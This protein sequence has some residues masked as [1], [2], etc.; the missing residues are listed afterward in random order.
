[1]LRSPIA[2][3]AVFIAF[4]GC[5]KESPKPAAAGPSAK[6]PE[7]ERSMDPGDGAALIRSTREIDWMESAGVFVGI[8]SFHSDSDLDVE[9]AADDAV[10]LAY[11]L[12]TEMELLQPRNT[13]ILLAG[14]PSKESSRAK[15]E[16]LRGKAIVIE[17]ERWRLAGRYCVNGDLVSETVA[18]MARE[19]G[20]DG[21]LIV[22]F[23]THGVT[24]NGEHRLLTADASTG[25]P[26]GVALAT[27]LAAIR[28]ER[29]ERLLLLID[30]C[31]QFPGRGA[32]QASVASWQPRAPTSFLEDGALELPYAVLASTGPG[33]LAYSDREVENGY[34]T[35]AT[36][37]G[38][39]CGASTVPDGYITLA[40]LET[41]VS[42]RVRELSHDFQQPESRIGG[43]G[44]LR[45]VDCTEPEKAGVIVSPEPN[46]AVE[47]AGV[48]EVRVDKSEMY[49]TV[50]VCSDEV[51][52]CYNQ[53]PGAK[54]IRTD[55]GQTIRV[56]AHYGKPG[57]FRIH[58][59]LTA[60]PHY[61]RGEQ[62]WLGVPPTQDANRLVYWCDP[63]DVTL[64]RR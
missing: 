9:Y 62:R 43:L 51:G 27:V 13:A 12:T 46:E 1:M 33:G 30:A 18:R 47:P 55:A 31:R 39:R 5:R 36:I 59:A 25:A 20:D 4:A 28:A 57:R 34:F 17:D 22:S 32:V 23:A 15:L 8:Q 58:A 2:L 24:S 64:K 3:L 26:H 63:V 37:E 38:L 10:D 60:D 50:I 44:S 49:A 21:I 7:Y 53:N 35:K 19:V 29:T 42:E 14:M 11:F 56:V 61:L 16:T 54:P 45:L 40:N 48:V 52:V 41:Y 6:A